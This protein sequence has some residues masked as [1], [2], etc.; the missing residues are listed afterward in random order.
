LK[1]DVV[2]FPAFKIG[3][4]NHG[5]KIS[6]NLSFDKQ[7]IMQKVKFLLRALIVVL[8]LGVL[9]VGGIITYGTITEYK[10]EPGLVEDVIISGTPSGE[11]PDSI[12][13]IFNWNLGF[14]GLGEEMDFFYDGGKNV[15]APR[16]I[17]DKDFPECYQLCKISRILTFL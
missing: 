15:R 4:V 1:I 8:I 7:T 14:G 16:E 9:F 10:P 11:Y 5:T 17:W 3:G 12:I 13:R 2:L 6:L